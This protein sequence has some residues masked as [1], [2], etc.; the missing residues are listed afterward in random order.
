MPNI[1]LTTR[2][3]I[4]T[5]T[6]DREGATANLFDGATL[7]ELAAIIDR[8]A[9]DPSVKGVLLK[10]AKPSIFIAGADLNVLSKAKGEELEKLISL[11]QDTFNRLEDLDVPTVAAIHGACV[12]GG[13]ELALACDWRIASDSKKTKIGLP[14]TQLGILPAWGGSTRLPK[15]IGLPTALALILGGNLLA[16]KAAKHKGVVDA[17]V[18][19]ENLEAFA[20]TW[21]GKGKRG[22]ERRWLVH[23]PF[24]VALIQRKAK[25]A[26]HAKTRGHYPGPAEALGVVGQSVLR[27]RALSLA[28]EREAI[29]RLSTR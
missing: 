29:V 26:L 21:I 7:E 22:R 25:A 8:I 18:P 19:E 2:D 14:E 9:A 27:P 4:A 24:S 1:I 23:N 5:I 16:A 3:G 6:F 11:G 12:G 20:S 10:S 17:V 13:L 28:A 15:L